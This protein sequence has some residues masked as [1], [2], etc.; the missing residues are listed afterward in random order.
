MNGIFLALLLTSAT[1]SFEAAMLDGR[2]V[3]GPIVELTPQR[4]TL[5]AGSGRVSIPTANL[6]T[7]LPKEK[8]GPAAGAAAVVVQLADG[9]V[10]EARQYVA[11]GSRAR[12]TLADGE[13]VEAPADMVQTVLCGASNRPSCNPTGRG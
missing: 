9:S 5:A 11:D 3:V 2:T 8:P 12:I 4:L 6:L 10:V 1:P 7:V 13:V